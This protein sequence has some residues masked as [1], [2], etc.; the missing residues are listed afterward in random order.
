L[1][2]Q[3]V[4]VCKVH[5]LPLSAIATIHV[6]IAR[7][8][9]EAVREALD[10]AGIPY[11]ENDRKA[12]LCW[13]DSLKEGD[14]IFSMVHG[15]QVVN[16]IPNMNVMCRK[17][18]LA[19]LIERLRP[20]FP[21]LFSF[22]PKSFILPHRKAKFM[23]ALKKSEFCWIVKPDG[24]SLGQG[25]TIVEPGSD[26]QPDETMAVA[27][28]YIDSCLLNNKKFDFR[29]YGLVA[30]V[31]P[32]EIYVY[33]EGLAR[34]CI[35][36]NDK[37]TPLGQLT[38]VAINHDSRILS[39]IL[40]RLK[41]EHG[42]DIDLIW[43]RIDAAV[44][45]TVISA[46]SYI[47]KGMELRFPSNSH[48]SRCFQILGFDILLDKAGNPYVLEVN[49]RPSLD[50]H[51]AAER[52][53]KVELAKFA[54]LIGCP[55]KLAQQTFLS[56]KWTEQAWE[57]AWCECPEIHNTA[58]IEKELAVKQ[59]QYEKI[60]PSED[61]DKAVWKEVLEKVKSLPV[62]FIPGVFSLHT[63]GK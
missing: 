11:E 33:R 31:D 51:F 6:S 39:E 58:K 7:N 30:S 23:R 62:E 12:I 37:R 45:L 24:G 22:M 8:A 46:Y 59:S 54:I 20:F 55:L 1:N 15:W 32:L 21:G 60:W 34:F 41:E 26:Y 44:G 27:Q 29:I 49:Y 3:K 40:E 63:V 35:E 14:R 28:K 50:T 56:R 57:D 16:R 42:F 48:Y 43:K 17:T 53:L 52:R 38:N 18:P 5:I 13:F 2:I 25:I 4:G 9:F 19:R 10:S 47:H 61:A 36:E